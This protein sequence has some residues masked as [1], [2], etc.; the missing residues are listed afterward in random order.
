[1]LSYDREWDD[2]SLKGNGSSGTAT[3][4]GL[5][6]EAKAKQIALAKAPSGATVVKCKLDRDD[7]RYVYEIEMRSGNM[8]YECDINAVTGVI[9]DWDADWDD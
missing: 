4:D 6:G 8:E 9:I 2:F 7:G 5:I 3:Q 1:M